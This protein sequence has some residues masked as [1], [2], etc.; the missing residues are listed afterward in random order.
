MWKN[1]IG[2]LSMIYIVLP[3]KFSTCNLEKIW[4]QWEI[5][6]E[7]DYDTMEIMRQILW[8]QFS[9]WS[10]MESCSR[11]YLYRCNI[12]C[13]SMIIYYKFYEKHEVSC[14]AT[15]N[16]GRVADLAY[17]IVNGFNLSQI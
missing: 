3:E 12:I 17:V 13:M 4:R 14:Y 1:M 10:L 15:N 2:K 8:R 5:L 6:W 9:F 7:N 11:N 16:T